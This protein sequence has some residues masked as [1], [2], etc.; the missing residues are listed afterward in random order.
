MNPLSLNFWFIV[1]VMLTSCSREPAHLSQQ[2]LE[3]LEKGHASEA[4]RK[5]GFALQSVLEESEAALLWNAVGVSAARTGREEDAEQAFRTALSLDP[6]LWVAHVNA[7]MLFSIQGN[8]EEAEA[9]FLLSLQ[10]EPHGS[11][12]LQYLA[13]EALRNGKIPEVLPRFQAAAT[14]NPDA[15]IL[16]TLAVLSVGSASVDQRKEWLLQAVTLDPQDAAAQ[17]NLA[18]LLDQHEHDP[19]QALVHYEAFARLTPDSPLLAKVQQRMRVMDRRSAAGSERPPDSVR[20]EVEA[21]LAKAEAATDPR[22]ALAFCLRAHAAASRAQ[23][24][25]LREKALRT[26]TVVA[27]DSSRAFVGLG[28]FYADQ[29]RNEEALASYETAYRLTPAWEP[30]WKGVADTLRT[31]GREREA[32]QILSEAASASD[33]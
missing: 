29:G 15:R 7:G 1:M 27:P 22:K 33:S 21:F 24:A 25:D 28:R 11:I 31:L 2:G 9:E 20:Q 5:F 19:E 16:S 4:H 18:A 30:A 14:R 6:S 13:L 26:G 23:R 12:A 17:L 32:D 3:Q 10:S 8:S